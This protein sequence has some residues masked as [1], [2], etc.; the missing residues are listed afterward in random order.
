MTCQHG[1]SGYKYGRNID[2]GSSHQKSRYILITVWHHNKGI[3]LMCKC[4]T[5]CRISDQVSGY[6]R[7]LHTYMSHGD[8]ITDSNRR[9][10]NRYTTCFC[11]AK[12]DSIYDLVKVHMSRNDLIVGAYNTD[13]GLLHFLFGK[14]KC[15]E[16]TS[17]RSLLHSFF[18][19][20]TS[21]FVSSLMPVY[22]IKFWFSYFFSISV[23]T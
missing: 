20:I 12:L 13:H 15:I 6:Q 23:F 10:Y 16:Q 17:V 11:H 5:L 9:K 22:K 4:H 2:P 1:T 19:V 14:A 8:S 3:K 7:V 18:Y 21:H